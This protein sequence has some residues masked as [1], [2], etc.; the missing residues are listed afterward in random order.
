LL[1][2]DSN[3]IPS[4]HFSASLN[5][6]VNN[7]QS[8]MATKSEMAHL[9]GNVNN[10]QSE[11]TATKSDMKSDMRHLTGKIDNIQSEMTHL[12]NNLTTQMRSFIETVSACQRA[13]SPVGRAVCE[14]CQGNV[15][16]GS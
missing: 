10:I 8:E 15:Y 2:D 11:M 1:D 12:N 6:K 16:K 9:T 14:E 3:A 13:A 4:P 5:D 7:I